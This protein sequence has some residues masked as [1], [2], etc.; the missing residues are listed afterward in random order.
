[1]R[2]V[3]L[4]RL[5]EVGDEVI[6]AAELDVDL[7]PRVLDAVPQADELVVERDDDDPQQDDDAITITT[8]S[9]S[10]RLP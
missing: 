9:Q 4:H 1:M 8:M 7:R 3:A 2:R 6:A 10:T 5:H